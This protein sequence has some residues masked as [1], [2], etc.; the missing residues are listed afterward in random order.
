MRKELQ[1]ALAFALI[2]AAYPVFIWNG[3][4]AARFGDLNQQKEGLLALAVLL[5]VI[6]GCFVWLYFESNLNIF[7]EFYTVIAKAFR[8]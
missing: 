4:R 3:I 7:A 6:P 5:F 8:A 2:A 1:D